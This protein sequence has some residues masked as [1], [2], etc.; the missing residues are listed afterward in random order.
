MTDLS[1]DPFFIVETICIVWFA[2][3]LFIRFWASPS[4]AD[5]IK[6]IMNIIDFIAIVPYFV[7]VLL[8]VTERPNSPRV[9][10]KHMGNAS[11]TLQ[12]MRFSRLFIASCFT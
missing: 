3:E 9:A 7:T 2:L 5:F 10:S 8:M 6:D 4:K 11:F 12:G 1:A